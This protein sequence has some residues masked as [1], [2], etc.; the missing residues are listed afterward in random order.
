VWYNLDFE[1]RIGSGSGTASKNKLD[2]DPFPNGIRNTGL[3]FAL[4]LYGMADVLLSAPE[5]ILYPL[6]PYFT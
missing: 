3:I 1:L 5:N 4:P 2:P 6:L